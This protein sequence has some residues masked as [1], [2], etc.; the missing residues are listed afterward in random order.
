MIPV[1]HN[2][3]RDPL[4]ATE[5]KRYASEREQYRKPGRMVQLPEEHFAAGR[6]GVCQS[7][8]GFFDGCCGQCGSVR[9]FTPRSDG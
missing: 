6:C 8:G 2:I 4:P 1:D 3:V 7:N 9:P 5:R